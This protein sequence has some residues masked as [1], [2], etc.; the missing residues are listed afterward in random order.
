MN[1]AKESESNE[2]SI[3]FISSIPSSEIAGSTEYLIMMSVV[4]RK[5]RHVADAFYRA[6]RRFSSLRDVLLL[7]DH[8]LLRADDHKNSRQQTQVVRDGIHSSYGT[9]HGHLHSAPLPFSQPFP[10]SG[11]VQ[12]VHNGHY[13]LP[14][15]TNFTQGTPDSHDGDVQAKPFVQFNS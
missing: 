2:P 10:T 3:I 4:F 9:R 1:L 8:T 15:V 12:V 5:I 14:C 6:R 7:R 11:V 13:L